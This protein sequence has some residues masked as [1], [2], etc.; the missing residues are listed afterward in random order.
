MSRSPVARALLGGDR[1]VVVVDFA[2]AAAAVVV[3]GVAVIRG[4]RLMG[5]ERQRGRRREP[6]GW[7]ARAQQRWEHDT[8]TAVRPDA[9]VIEPAVDAVFDQTRNLGHVLKP[10]AGADEAVH[11]QVKAVVVAEGEGKGDAGGGC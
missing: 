3:V 8:V 6:S 4:G 1:D 2:A 7:V 11:G 5:G 9:A 10:A